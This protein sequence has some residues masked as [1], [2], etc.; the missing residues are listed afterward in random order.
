MSI[1]VFRRRGARNIARIIL[2]LVLAAAA[3]RSG[4][5]EETSIKGRWRDSDGLSEVQ[6]APCEAGFL[7]GTIVWLKEAHKDAN[8]PDPAL[9]DRPLLGLKVIT[10][11]EATHNPA[12]F[13]AQGY[14]PEDGRTYQTT[15]E[16]QSRD[17]LQIKGCVLGGLVCDDDMWT[18]TR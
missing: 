12:R 2:A 17:R 9:R 6:I 18:R 8:N 11:I 10:K 1:S 16:L 5:A 14:N 4:E 7:C 13:S 15:L 3:A